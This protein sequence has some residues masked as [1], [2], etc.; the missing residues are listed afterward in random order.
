MGM[1]EEDYQQLLANQREAGGPAP[2]VTLKEGTTKAK[3]RKGKWG[4]DQNGNKFWYDSA[5]EVKQ[6]L[7]L[8]VMKQAGEIVEWYP[9]VSFELLS[10]DAVPGERG[11]SYKSDFVLVR[12]QPSGVLSPFVEKFKKKITPQYLQAWSRW[13][14]VAEVW[15]TKAEWLRRFR[16]DWPIRRKLFKLFYPNIK[17]REIIQK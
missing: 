8:Q 5:L 17:L 4:V 9:Q 3:R 14:G 15:E 13:G 1:S 2:L 10:K 7:T 11:V 6:V 16:A 12:N